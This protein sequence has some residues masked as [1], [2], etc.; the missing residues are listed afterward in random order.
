MDPVWGWIARLTLAALFAAAGLSKLYRPA[1]FRA[2]VA[3]Y[4]L[5]PSR[6]VAPVALALASAE[7]VAALLLLVPASRMAGASLLWAM[8]ALFSTAIALSIQRGRLDIDCGCWLFGAADQSAQRH[9]GW[10]TVAR[11]GGLAALV[12]V[13]VL[14]GTDRLL[15]AIDW[16]TIL[17]GALAALG[18]FAVATQLGLNG[19]L[20]AGLKAAKP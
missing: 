12:L 13:A 17:A 9:I 14:P 11:N 2:A 20:L 10:P 15:D 4:E 1:A 5:V 18:L 19:R 7:L 6:A 16:L 8:L 3:A